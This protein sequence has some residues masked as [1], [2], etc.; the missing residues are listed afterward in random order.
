MVGAIFGVHVP[1]AVGQQ[2]RRLAQSRLMRTLPRKYRRNPFGKGIAMKGK[3][4]KPFAF[5]TCGG[6]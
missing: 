4:P 5:K 2:T 3:A 6:N 1:H